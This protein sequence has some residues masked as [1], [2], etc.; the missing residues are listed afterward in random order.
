MDSGDRVLALGEMYMT[1]SLLP[2]A[3][4]YP[5]EH[6]G[7]D[8]RYWDGTAWV[9]PADEREKRRSAGK[10]AIL[11]GTV[12]RKTGL[13]V[14]GSALVVGLFLGGGMG[15]AG[16]AK[17]VTSLKEHVTSL[18]TDIAAA[19]TAA[20]ENDTVLEEVRANLD[21]AY[22][23][24]D[25]ALDELATATAS[26]T[27]ATSQ[28]TDMETAA[29]ASQTELDAR[30]ARIADLEGQ[31]SSRSVQSPVSQEP[32][33]VAPAAPAYAYYEN[34][35]AARSAGAAPVRSGDPGYGRHLDRDGD[36]VG[37]E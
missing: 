18:E 5:A 10:T 32:V 12:S 19:D 34:C 35:T 1:E 20:A 22:A 6:A 36:G 28:I 14:T 27:T 30:A 13:I 21:E 26:L 17:E 8:L 33:A 11:A 16:A 7:G 25:T 4:W 15:G 37:C 9:E 2:A 23:D 24:L 29:T 31:L 3:G